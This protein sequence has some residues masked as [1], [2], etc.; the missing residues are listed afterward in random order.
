MTQDRYATYVTM[1][2]R[3]DRCAKP[4]QH[5]LG[6]A[7]ARAAVTVKQ[8]CKHRLHLWVV[9]DSNGKRKDTLEGPSFVTK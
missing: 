3:I 1:L 7:K 2:V 9:L 6:I 5:W 8:R 4:P